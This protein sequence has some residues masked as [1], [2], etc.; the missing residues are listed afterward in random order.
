M[1]NRLLYYLIIIPFSHLPLWILYGLSDFLYILIITIF[2]Y[3]RKVALDNI[4]RC[5]PD[6]S[7]RDRKRLLRKNYRH[8]CNILAESIKNLSISQKE[9]KKRFIIENPDIFTE[10]NNNG[11]SVIIISSHYSNWE[12]LI[13]VQNLIIPQLAI[14]IGKPLSTKFLNKKIN[15]LRERNG[16]VVVSALNYKDEIVGRLKGG[17]KLAILALADQAPAP[18]NAFWTKHFNIETP[19]PFG[20]EFMAHQYDFPVVFL[21][22]RMVKRGYYVSKAELITD[23]PKEEPFSMIMQSFAELLE[24]QIREK[25]DDWLWTHKRWKHPVP[26]NIEEVKNKQ[27]DIFYKRFPE[28]RN[29]S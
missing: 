4:T 5:F 20:P 7:N 16:M 15:G 18:Q 21:G 8:I 3:R 26:E 10:L 11:K 1:H 22:T 17:E 28:A 24:K 2:P 27:K 9:L 25:P 23:K 6:I 29:K 13:T 12:F 14:G 19:F